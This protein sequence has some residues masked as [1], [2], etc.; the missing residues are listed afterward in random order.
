MD[1]H[2]HIIWEREEVRTRYYQS[3][4]MGHATAEK[5]VSVFETA[6]SDLHARNLLQLS[7]DGPNVNWKLYDLIQS[8][9][10]KDYHKSMVNTGSCGLHIVCGAFEHGIDASGWNVDEF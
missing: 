8:R 9:L 5:M 3:E 2:G 4:F 1:F 6:T 10:Q 7:M